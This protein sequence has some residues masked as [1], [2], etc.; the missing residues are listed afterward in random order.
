MGKFIGGYKTP[1]KVNG[2]IG[3]VESWT[4]PTCQ[5][6]VSDF[7]AISRRDN[8]TEICSQCGVDEALRDY[9]ESEL[10]RLKAKR[11]KESSPRFK[12]GNG[13]AKAFLSHNPTL[14]F[15]MGNF[16]FYEDPFQGDDV[17]M[18]ILTPEGK[19][20][21]NQIDDRPTEEEFDSDFISSCSEYTPPSKR[22]HPPFPRTRKGGQHE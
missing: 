22:L 8:V 3:D 16:L 6:I 7:P 4:C 1:R 10:A 15:K 5:K 2:K 19:L 11:D 12:L 13:K 18:V 20:L 9:Y 14:W 21:W 17:P